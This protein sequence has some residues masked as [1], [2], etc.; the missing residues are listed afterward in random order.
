[1]KSL[2]LK[3]MPENIILIDQH[4]VAKVGTKLASA[5]K[6][7]FN[8]H[9]LLL[10]DNVATV[11]DVKKAFNCN[12]K[13]S[14]IIFIEPGDLAYKPRSKPESFLFPKI[15]GI[16]RP[17]NIPFGLYWCGSIYRISNYSV[18]AKLPFKHSK[19]LRQRR[20][21]INATTPLK[22]CATA[23]LV[24]IDHSV[25]FLGQPYSGYPGNLP[26]KDL[27]RHKIIH[28]QTKPKITNYGK[29]TDR[30]RKAFKM[31]EGIVE[32]EI[33]KYPIPHDLVIKKMKES[34]MCVHAMNDWGGAWGYAGI[35]A[36]AT[37]CLVFAKINHKPVKGLIDSGGPQRFVQIV[38]DLINDP[39]RF[40][41]LRQE[42]WQFCQDHFTNESIAQRFKNI[43][44][45]KIKGGWK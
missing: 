13:K 18:T 37:G 17:I 32:T 36:S 27:S 38:K 28:I 44:A 9:H 43:L 33:P 25:K 39:E 6:L 40:K 15:Y 26:T 19:H 8:V 10:R 42:Q 22:M 16:R 11:S 34:T 29:G 1:M 2:P 12:P 24:T 4:N 5:L 30:V 20:A 14:L 3:R 45:Q 35:E 23:D 41:E 7:K 31:L 21:I